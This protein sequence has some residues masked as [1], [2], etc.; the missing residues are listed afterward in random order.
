MTSALAGI[1]N[2][3]LSGSFV[4]AALT[5][6]NAA[7]YM[8]SP[9]DKGYALSKSTGRIFKLGVI[10]AAFTMVAQSSRDSP[11]F[12]TEN[13]PPKIKPTPTRSSQGVMNDY[14]RAVFSASPKGPLIVAFSSE[15]GLDP[16]IDG[17]MS[18]HSNNGND[19][20]SS[21]IPLG[22]DSSSP[23]N[24]SAGDESG[25]SNGSSPPTPP[26]NFASGNTLL[27]ST[28]SAKTPFGISGGSPPPPPPPPPPSFTTFGIDDGA[29]TPV[30][31]LLLTILCYI[32]GAI[33]IYL[34][35]TRRAK[36]SRTRY[37]QPRTNPAQ[38]SRYRDPPF[39]LQSVNRM[40]SPVSFRITKSAT[41]LG[42]A[43]EF[44]SL[45]KQRR[46]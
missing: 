23:P 5:S 3:G 27:E 37:Q 21:R 26:P 46:L 6:S 9:E 44:I 22:R 1:I 17:D 8:K 40:S 30:S 45:M 4:Q 12:G 15:N 38:K 42:T 19:R 41:V 35:A 11:D 10:A 2:G 13:I 34:Q 24:N 28:S 14:Y 18:G 32:I 43:S 33:Y 36:H 29:S 7:L 39:K 31:M 16:A 20:R 25:R